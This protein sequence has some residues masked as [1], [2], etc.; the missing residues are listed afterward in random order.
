VPDVDA[1]VDRHA[2]TLL[3]VVSTATPSWSMLPPRA[4]RRGSPPRPTG[5]AYL[6]RSGGP[7][8]L[9]NCI[10]VA[11]ACVAAQ[12]DLRRVGACCSASSTA[13]SPRRARDST[14]GGLTI[15]ER[16]SPQERETLLEAMQAEPAPSLEQAFTEI[17]PDV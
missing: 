1:R 2:E 6:R 13:P 16:A 8:E 14:H 11:A 9:A 17:F 3:H 10:F 4:G 12:G 5:A 7:I 15:L